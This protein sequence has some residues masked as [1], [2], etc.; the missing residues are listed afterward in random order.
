[1]NNQEQLPEDECAEPPPS[2]GATTTADDTQTEKVSPVAITVK[3]TEQESEIVEETAA[4]QV[5]EV[6]IESEQERV[7][8]PF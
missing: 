1:M 7:L 4:E 6:K 2:D 8:K 3:E 5:Q